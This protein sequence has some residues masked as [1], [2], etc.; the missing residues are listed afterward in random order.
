VVKIKPPLMIS[1]AEAEKVMEV[2]EQVT[3]V[4]SRESAGAR[5]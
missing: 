3:Q 4:L 1:E 2:F 5:T